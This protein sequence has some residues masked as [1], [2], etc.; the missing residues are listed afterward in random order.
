MPRG[1]AAKFVNVFTLDTG[2]ATD[3]NFLVTSE[4]TEVS[5]YYYDSEA[6]TVKAGS[7]DNVM[8]EDG[9]L[10]TFNAS[11]VFIYYY[12]REALAVIIKN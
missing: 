11:E 12:K 1:Y 8:T 6:E 7:F 3:K 2:A 10:G 9:V 4:D 5:Y